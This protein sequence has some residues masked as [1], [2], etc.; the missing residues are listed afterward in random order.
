MGHTLELLFA[1]PQTRKIEPWLKRFHVVERPAA[2]ETRGLSHQTHNYTLGI[3]IGGK[4][5]PSEG[6]GT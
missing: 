5:A 6:G 4:D 3:R 2:R 1:V